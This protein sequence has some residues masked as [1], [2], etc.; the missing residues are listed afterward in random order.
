[1]NIL[2]DGIFIDWNETTS[3]WYETFSQKYLLKNVTNYALV[4]TVP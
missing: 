4:D 3:E 1:M 2:Y